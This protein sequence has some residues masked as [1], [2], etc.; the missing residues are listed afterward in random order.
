M[1]LMVMMVESQKCMLVFSEVEVELPKLDGPKTR[2]E[3]FFIC[4]FSSSAALLRIT[5]SVP[6]APGFP[7]PKVGEKEEKIFS[8]P[9]L[10]VGC[11]KVAVKLESQLMKVDDADWSL[12]KI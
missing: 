4:L 7:D 3:I 5:T 9:Q 12:C 6:L 8:W 10:E 11:V 1:L 2:A